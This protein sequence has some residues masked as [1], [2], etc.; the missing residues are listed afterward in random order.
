[1]LILNKLMKVNKY[2]KQQD[3]SEFSGWEKNELKV[4]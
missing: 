4:L 1:M 2:Y 3:N